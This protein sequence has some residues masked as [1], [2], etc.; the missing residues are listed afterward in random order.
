MA[1]SGSTVGLQNWRHAGKV[2]SSNTTGPG[3]S[4]CA[5]YQSS[6]PR[7][8]IRSLRAFRYHHVFACARVMSRDLR[9]H[10]TLSH[11]RWL[12]MSSEL[13]LSCQPPLN[14]NET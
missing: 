7:L 5:L 6:V 14:L 9:L 2:L 12:Y 13:V 4:H 10:E 1:F 3:E 8:S 11:V